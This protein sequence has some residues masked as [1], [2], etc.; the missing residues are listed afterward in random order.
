[1]NEKELYR[2][3][4]PKAFKEVIG[5][6]T[7]VGLLQDLIKRDAVPHVILFTGPSGCGKTT[8]ARIMQ[9]KL[10]CN[11]LD[12]N[13][14]NAAKERG[15]EMVRNISDAM[16]LAPMGGKCR[17]WLIDECAR[18]THD[19]QSSLL[20]MLEDT[21]DH[22]YFF[23]ATT[24]PEKL[25]KTIRTR[26][27]QIACEALTE[28][29]ITKLCKQVAAQEKRKLAD[30]VYQSIAERCDGSARQA[31][32]FLHKVLGLKDT[33]LQLKAIERSD[34][35]TQGF[36]LAKALF[37]GKSWK[38]VAEIL[39]GMKDLENDTSY[40]TVRKTILSY[41]TTTTL[42]GAKPQLG[43]SIFRFFQ[44]PFFD[45][46]FPGLVNACFEF[47]HAQKGK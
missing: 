17:I 29:A 47:C 38:E 18:L 42:N 22:V 1:M 32:V 26:C 34:V 14:I 3:Y 45:N 10:E 19:G 46:K 35:K 41:V 5:Q 16:S 33:E 39:K 15:I 23:L 27:T 20:K 8:L 12:F 31:L 11:D 25:L 36:D 24:D 2:R 7:A 21:P 28:D 40:E 37:N 9:H 13:E 4:R 30:D 6:D 43:Q 44:Y